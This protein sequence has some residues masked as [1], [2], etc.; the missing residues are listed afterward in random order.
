M[1]KITRRTAL[2]L[3]AL[4]PT[5]VATSLK[6]GSHAA[7][8]VV[9]SGFSFSPAELEVKAGEAVRFV[10]QDN[11]PH[12]A[13]ADDGSFDTGR[14]NNGQSIEVEIPAGEHSYKC[15]FHPSMQGVIRAS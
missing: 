5:A 15:N 7:H 1:T 2:G 4:V 14:L 11:A 3:A 9:I 13:T 6:A 10:N 12:T 8:E